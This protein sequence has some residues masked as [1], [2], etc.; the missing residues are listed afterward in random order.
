MN[1]ARRVSA[2][3]TEEGGGLEWLSPHFWRRKLSWDRKKA[4]SSSKPLYWA[5]DESDPWFDKLR[6][7]N[8]DYFEEQRLIEK[9]HREVGHM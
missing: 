5:Q 9:K 8:L 2:G 1:V 3:I 4:R 7:Q 6:L